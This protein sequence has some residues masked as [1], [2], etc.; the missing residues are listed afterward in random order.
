[1]RLSWR[2]TIAVCACLLS[3]LLLTGCVSVGETNPQ[4]TLPS[5]RL[6]SWDGTTLGVPI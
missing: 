2:L 6:A 4:S 5:N 1:M 3:A